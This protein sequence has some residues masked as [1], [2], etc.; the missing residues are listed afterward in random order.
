MTRVIENVTLVE[1]RKGDGAQKYRWDDDPM[2]VVW[3]CGWNRATN[4][5]V[6]DVG[7]LEYRTTPS[8]GLYWF[9]PRREQPESGPEAESAELVKMV[10]HTF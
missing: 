8:S 9:V 10:T 3:L 7:R 1:K 4:V 6:G 5:S 2:H